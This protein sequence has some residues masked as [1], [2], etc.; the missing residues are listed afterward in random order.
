MGNT[1]LL[2]PAGDLNILKCAFAAGADAVYFG[3]DSFGARVSAGF[4]VED[5]ISA[6][7][8]AH[9]RGKKVYITVNTLLKN[10]EMERRLYDFLSTYDRA[11]VDGIIVQDMGVFSFARKFFPNR[12]LH[13]STQMNI[14]T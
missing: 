12:P 2:A 6:I 9:S 13:A 5:G 4:S 10:V 8:Y 14:T 7:E 1:E 11:F 3:G